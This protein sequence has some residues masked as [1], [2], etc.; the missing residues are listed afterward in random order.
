[1]FIQCKSL[2]CNMIIPGMDAVLNTEVRLPRHT[3]QQTQPVGPEFCG[4]ETR[5]V[6]GGMGTHETHSRIII[7]KAI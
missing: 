2:V 3:R 5:R 4:Q 1:M 6:A 7:T